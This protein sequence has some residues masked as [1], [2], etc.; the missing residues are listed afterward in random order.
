MHR[1]LPPP[2]LPDP[3]HW[4]T[5]AADTGWEPDALPLMLLMMV[6]R[7]MIGCAASLSEPLHCRTDVTRSVECV[8]NVPFPCAQGPREQCRVTVVVELVFLPL[9][10]LTTV[11]LQVIPVVAPIAPGP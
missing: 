1:T 7:Q 2:P 6:T 8:T 4:F 3:T 9:M 5:V 10:V 11:T